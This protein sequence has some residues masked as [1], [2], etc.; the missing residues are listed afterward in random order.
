MNLSYVLYTQA[1]EQPF[2]TWMSSKKQ[3]AT[4]IRDIIIS[5]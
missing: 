5:E 2:Q 1:I 4:I 3:H